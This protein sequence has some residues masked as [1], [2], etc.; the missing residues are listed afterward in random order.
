MRDWKEIQE[1]E[2]QIVGD[3]QR[4]REPLATGEHGWPNQ[5]PAK[6]YLLM[7]SRIAA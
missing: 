3:E 6:G 2:A 1:L 5:L 7:T 4:C